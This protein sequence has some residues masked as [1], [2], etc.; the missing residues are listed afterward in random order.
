M[1]LGLLTKNGRGITETQGPFALRKKSGRGSCSRRRDIRPKRK[2]P[3]ISIGKTKSAMGLCPAHAMLKK[4]VVID[5][6]RCDLFIRPAIKDIHR[7]LFDSAA[8]A[9]LRA[10]VVAHSGG[11][12]GEWLSHLVHISVWD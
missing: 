9:R 12:S 3:A 5:G 1:R 2:E 6:W 11:N 10:K 4:R 8:Q 7:R